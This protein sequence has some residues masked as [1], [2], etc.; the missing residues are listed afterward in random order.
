MAGQQNLRKPN[1]PDVRVVF[2]W[3]A[4][5]SIVQLLGILWGYGEERNGAMNRAATEIIPQITLIT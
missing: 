5:F 1:H 2:V 3:L 4:G